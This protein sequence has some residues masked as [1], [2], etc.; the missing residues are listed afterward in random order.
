[1]GGSFSEEV[2]SKLTFSVIAF[3]QISLKQAISL[4]KLGHN[5]IS[6]HVIQGPS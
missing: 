5:W 2:K 4:Q 3:C 6:E 1:M